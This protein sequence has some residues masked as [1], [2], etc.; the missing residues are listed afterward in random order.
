MALRE[1]T[2]EYRRGAADPIRLLHELLFWQVI[3]AMPIL[4][5]H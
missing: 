5:A 1:I 3:Y 4:S 2:V